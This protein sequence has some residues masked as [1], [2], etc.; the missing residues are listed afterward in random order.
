VWH[1]AQGCRGWVRDG[2][3]VGDRGDWRWL[4]YHRGTVYYDTSVDERFAEI[5]LPPNVDI[6]LVYII[7]N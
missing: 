3:I 1:L 5:L 2:C 7:E 6:L 4:K